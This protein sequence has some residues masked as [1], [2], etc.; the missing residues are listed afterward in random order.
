MKPYVQIGFMPQGAVDQARAVPAPVDAR[1]RS[2]TRSTPAGPT[3]RRTTTKWGE[4]VYQWA[5][6]CVEKYGTRRGRAVVLG[7]LERAEHRLLARHAARSSTSCTTTRSTA[8]AARCRRRASAG[9]TRPAAAASSR[10][11]SSSTA[12]AAPTTPPARSARRSTSS[13]STPRASPTF[14]DGHVRM[15]IANQLATIDEGFRIVASF[16]ELKD[17]P[18]VIGESDPDGCAACQGPQL[19]YRNGTMY[20]SYTAASFARKHD[21]ADQHGVNLEGALTWAFEFEDQPYFAGFRVLATQRHRPAGAQRLPH[22]QP[23]GRRSGWRST[24]DGA[25]PLD[26]ILQGRRP[27]QARRRRAG[28]P[29]RRHALR[30]GLALPRR[31]RARPGRRRST[32]TLAGL[33]ARAGH[34]AAAALPHRRATTATPSP[35][36]SGWARPP[37][38]RRSSTPSSRQRASWPARGRSRRAWMWS[39]AGHR[40]RSPCRARRCRCSCSSGESGLRPRRPTPGSTTKYHQVSAQT[41]RRV[42]APVPKVSRRAAGSVGSVGAASFANAVNDA[43]SKI[44]D[45]LIAKSGKQF[46]VR[47][48][49]R[50]MMISENI[51]EFQTRADAKAPA[52]ADNYS[53]NSFNANFA[54]VWVNAA[55]GMVKVAAF[56]G[57]YGG[58]ENSESK[59]GALANHRWQCMGHWNG[60]D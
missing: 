42:P 49:A 25:V 19:G 59:N 22:V 46:F 54:E 20:S 33:P 23:D 27:R 39:M 48:T 58:R 15:G 17:K 13:R 50:Q 53:C 44:T 10:A 12:C 14:V 34:G 8:C 26:A 5:K 45:E 57:G 37:R 2:T 56:P 29:R 6:H 38:R 40:C 7:D 41:D 35:R 24:S 21:L 9:R 1:R 52:E 18:I 47:P 36:G 31:R 28:Q 16:P 11:T 55:T 60:A 32:L 3:R 51:S 30:P 4:L 43:C